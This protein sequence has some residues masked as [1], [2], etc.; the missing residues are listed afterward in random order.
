MA[1]INS[2]LHAMPEE[3][4]RFVNQWVKERQIYVVAMQ[5]FPDFTAVEL[6]NKNNLGEALTAFE[7]LRR[8]NLGLEPPN[9]SVESPY[10][11]W[12]KNPNDLTID[13]GQLTTNK[14]LTESAIST[15]PQNMGDIKLWQKF[16]RDFKKGSFTGLWA[17]SRNTGHRGFYKNARFT[18]G[19]SEFA[20]SGGKLLSFV[21]GNHYELDEQQSE[22]S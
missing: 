14:E 6:P 4:I 1:Y 12:N 20:K 11:F 13:V 3:I 7:S 2:Q 21:G 15:S 16:A 18:Q 8:I 17:V 19:A 5:F 9:L 10:D 22:T